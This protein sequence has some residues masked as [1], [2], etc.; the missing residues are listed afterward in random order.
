MNIK[1]AI[2]RLI[3]ILIV[4]VAGI[5]SLSRADVPL[6]NTTAAEGVAATITLQSLGRKLIGSHYEEGVYR[7]R[8][9]AGFDGASGDI[10]IDRETGIVVD[11]MTGKVD[12]SQETGPPIISSTGALRI[13]RTF[14][15][16]SGIEPDGVW[17][18][19]DNDY[20]EVGPGFRQYNLAWH[21]IFGGVQL[22]SSISVSLDADSGQVISY[23][24]I[25]DPVTIPVQI[26]LTGEQALTVV[27]EKK[28]WSH[29]ALKRANLAIWYPNGYPGPQ[30]L[31]WRFE[32]ANPDAKTGS[33]SYVWADVNATTGQIVRLDGPAG[34]FGPMPKGQKA[35]SVALPKPDLGAL[36]G[37]KP[38]PTV[39]QLAKLRQGKKA[40]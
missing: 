36:R 1:P 25:D 6:N 29:P 21:R 2:Y 39:F 17:T 30:A 31:M 20:H 35:V 16:G 4:F 12:V 40:K 5:A 18:L 3:S 28:G 8:R 19:T 34:F 38:P 27:S 32:V 26:N 11:Y 15:R 13:G 37:A 7:G 9:V 23:H 22:P 33:D 14:L 10:S 24:L